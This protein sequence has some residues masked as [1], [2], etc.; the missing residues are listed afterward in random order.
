MIFVLYPEGSRGR[1]IA[2]LCYILTRNKRST[3]LNDIEGYP[4]HS[5]FGEENLNKP[6]INITHCNLVIEKYKDAKMGVPIVDLH[7]TTIDT[8]V[9]IVE[10]GHRVIRI[11]P[12]IKNM[13]R[14]VDEWFYKKF[15]IS[16]KPSS[17]KTMLVERFASC[18]SAQD[19]DKLQKISSI[20]LYQWSINDLNLLRLGCNVFL[21][22]KCEDS[23]SYKLRH[24]SLTANL[25]YLELRYC[26]LN[27]HDLI[28]ESLTSF[29]NVRTN[30]YF[31]ER[32]NRYFELHEKIPPFET[33]IKTYI[34]NEG[35]INASS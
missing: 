29:L 31:S 18:L 27:R 24:A 21:A 19:D 3:H 16:K 23:A 12:V 10:Q 30:D 8:M 9:N 32:F 34:K 14:Y 28:Q 26:D 5:N 22:N 6:N 17:Q 35:N 2:E 25:D 15:I 1:F 13:T 33:Y 11:I 7:F 4:E 20:P